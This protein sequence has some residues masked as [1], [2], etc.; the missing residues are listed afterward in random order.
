M[1]VKTT[2]F[3]IAGLLCFSSSAWAQSASELLQSD[4]QKAVKSFS[5]ETYF[6]HYFNLETGAHHIE[7]TTLKEVEGRQVYVNS[8]L[9][10]GGKAFRNFERRSTNFSNAGPGI[11]LAIDPFA[12]S[13]AAA[14]DS[15]G[16][17]GD[18]MIELKI[19]TGAKY[20]SVFTPTAVSQKTV[21]ALIEEGYLNRET[22]K[23]LLNG[24]RLSRDT[25]KFMVGYGS[26][27][28]R[29]LMADLLVKMNVNMIEYAWQSG[30]GAFCGWKD[31]RSAFVY[32]AV[33][34]PSDVSEANLVYWRGFS[35][36]V[37]L[38]EGETESLSRSKALHSLL[39]QLR[40]LEK[41]MKST[42]G[43]TARKQIRQDVQSAIKAA[44]PNPEDVRALKQHI[45]KCN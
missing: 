37:T 33:D 15:G 36:N 43:A 38:S 26:E 12:S 22:A 8:R 34:R 7:D 20:L 31:M 9:A 21:G 4:L 29:E 17:F 14:Q 44:Y 39:V 32:I 27:S 42:Q 28:F 40:V 11:Y 35:S 23:K 5:Q 19:Q 30:V 45:F 3:I 10:L 16:F 41:K 13:G 25:F 6:Y 2:K 1:K 18:S 24:N